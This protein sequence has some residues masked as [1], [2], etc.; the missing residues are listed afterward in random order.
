MKTT[1][2]GYLKTLIAAGLLAT[3]APAF[4]Q[5]PKPPSNEPEIVQAWADAW[6]AADGSAMSRLFTADGVYEDYAF[7]AVWTDPTRSRS[8]FK[9][10]RRPFRMPEWKFSTPIRLETERR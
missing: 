4:A 10:Q 8:G 7:Q 1:K 5:A 9:S 2:R 6:N 3:A